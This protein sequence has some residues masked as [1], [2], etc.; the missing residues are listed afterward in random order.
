MNDHDTAQAC[1]LSPE[2]EPPCTAAAVVAIEDRRQD[3]VWGCE[4]HAASALNAIEG[5]RIAHVADWSAARRLLAL[6]WNHRVEGS[7]R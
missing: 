2:D 5:A 4:T 1:R 3:V 6:P 7:A